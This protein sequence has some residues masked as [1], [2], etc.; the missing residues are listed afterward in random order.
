MRAMTRRERLSLLRELVTGRRALCRAPWL[1]PE[2]MRQWQFQRVRELVDHAYHTV[3]LYAE[4]YRRAGFRPGELRSWEDFRALPL[5]SKDDLIEAYPD[6]AISRTF[7]LKDLIVS[8]S[9]GSS[10]KVLDL[11]YPASTLIRY[12][13][14]T[15]RVY[16][17][18]F[19][20]R[21]WHRHVYIYT[22]PYPF[23]SIFGL[24]PLR[25]VSTLEPIE[26]ILEV[27]VEERPHLLVCYPS[28]LRQV[29]EM[30][31]PRQLASV[32]PRLVSLNSEMSSQAER[33][34]LEKVFGCPA[35]DN[36]ASEELARIAAQCAHKTYHV[37]D[38]MNYLEILDASDAPTDGLG[39]VVGTNLH[40]WAMPL[41]RYRQADLGALAASTC[42]CGWRFRVLEDLQ[43]RQ[44]DTFVLPS[45]R[46]LTSGF[47]L[48]A[49]Y[50]FLLTH[51]F[52][53]RDFCLLQESPSAIRL[54][55]VPGG[56]YSEE[57]AKHVSARF[58]EFLEPEV[59]FRVEAVQEC[60]KTRTGKRNPIISYCAAGAGGRRRPIPPPPPAPRSAPPAR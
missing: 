60:E 56:G 6:A 46:V 43:G 53:I 33:N 36:Y 34:H 29:A 37:F 26:R 19:S 25:F 13:L 15:L 55:L 32:R 11:A 9:S 51:R 5:V 4:L 24:Y 54:E 30:A 41:I 22:S 20:Y 35:L 3:P 23:R 39:H 40:N 45:G 21:P 57:V 59:A 58:R 18:G 52:E 28:H 44:N 31:S 48:D 17:M 8:R 42:P 47:L 2:E 49:T 50:E 12:A 16:E 7:D 38:D 27:L 1:S 10:G 14:A